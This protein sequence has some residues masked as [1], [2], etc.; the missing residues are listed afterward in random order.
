M[1]VAAGLANM[2]A[3]RKNF[4]VKTNKAGLNLREEPSTESKI[5]QLIPNGE[6]VTIDP[7]AEA[8]EGWVAVRGGGYVMREFLE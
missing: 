1:V 7:V 8:P 4:T 5:I 2:A 3:P 6:K